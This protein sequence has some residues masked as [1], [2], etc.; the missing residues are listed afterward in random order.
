MFIYALNFLFGILLFSLKNA[1]LI[2][3]LEW[4][5]LFVIIL[6]I[7]LSFKRHKVVALSLGFFLLGFAWMG[8]IS[9]QTLSTQIKE[10][11]LNKPI[12]VT[13][14]VVELPKNTTRNTKFIFKAH[15]PFQGKLKLAW[16]HHSPNLRT[17][18]AWQLLVKIKHNNS[19]QNLGGFDYEK[20]LFYKRIDATGYV[21]A[22]PSNQRIDDAN[23]TLSIDQIRQAIRHSLAPIL[24]QQEFG[25]II[26]ALIIGDRSLIS[27]KHWALFKATNT[28]H[29][30]V[31][32]GLHIGLISGFMFLLIQF[33]WRYSMRLS[34]VMPSQVAAA[35]FGLGS[36]FVYALI[37]GFSVPTGRAFIMASVLF[38]AIIFRRHHNT[39][40]LYGIA[41]FLVL[42]NDPLNIFSVGF[43]LSFYVVA[44]IIYGSHQHQD[45]SWLY[46]LI[47]LQLLINLATL[48]LTIWFFSAGSIVSPIANLI[49]I[50]IF[51]FAVIPL[52]LI[53]ALLHFTGLAYLSVMVFSIANQI[54]LYLT[55]I[56]E[57]LQQF[58]FNQWHYSQTSL[59][60]LT[61]FI[62]AMFIALSPKGLKLRWLSIP[63]L[64]LL[65]LTPNHTI[66][67]NSMLVTT[68]DVGQGLAHVI[69]TRNH[70]LLFDTGARYASGFDLGDSVITPYLR[71]KHI[72]HLD[73]VIISHDDNDHIGGLNNILQNFDITEILSSVP[74]KIPT[75]ATNCQAGQ[76][77]TWDGVLFEILSPNKKSKLTD[78]NASC[79]L[80]VSNQ[81]YSIL[82]TG[83][84]EKATE[85]HL[86]QNFTKKLKSTVLIS[87]H[88]GSKTSSTQAFLT[89]VSPTL[90]II[91][92]GFQNRF[93]HPHKT[94]LQRYQANNIQTLQTQCSGQIDLLFT[95]DINIKEYRKDAKRYYLRQ[96]Y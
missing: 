39:W 14:K 43:W 83:D 90:V 92:S 70:I 23:Q 8:I 69:Q 60:D 85:R 53:G 3:V 45:K 46:R 51:S 58:E 19:Y 47:Y 64:G 89:A 34:R 95:H 65:F 50:P 10:S 67:H 75:K 86:V 15:S 78:N 52:A 6:T 57:Q 38:L 22:S 12:L 35:F 18:D 37:A 77:W 74:E 96:C 7:L 13:G 42:A 55:I 82:L 26:N 54:L 21:R 49:A 36:A 9:A 79:V 16:Y 28:T 91:S 73:K 24:Q 87:P 25:G 41:L 20:W 44:V 4:S 1:L 94:I 80:K 5:A 29:L 48:P 2:T 17:G 66:K 56:L 11:Y 81:K 63:I 59:V 30:S 62:L 31:I 27:T 33:L 71:A 72:Q 88:H 93:H 76:N 84:I 61:L 32:S 40:Q 68:L